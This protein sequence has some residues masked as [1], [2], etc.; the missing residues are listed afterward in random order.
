MTPSVIVSPDA[1]DPAA[2][3]ATPAPLDHHP[4]QNAAKSASAVDGTRNATD[5]LVV[6][7]KTEE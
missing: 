4:D 3:P 2:N 7:Q 1:Q 5:G 6:K